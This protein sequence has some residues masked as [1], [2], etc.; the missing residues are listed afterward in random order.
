MKIFEMKTRYQLLAQ[1][2]LVGMFFSQ[3]LF[4][5]ATTFI[6]PTNGVQNYSLQLQATVSDIP[7]TITIE[8]PKET[9]VT[10]Y[11]VYRKLKNDTSWGSV[12]AT[13]PYNA[14]ATTYT[15]V[16]TNV[17]VGVGYEY[18]V[19][20]N[21]P[22]APTVA[23][24]YIY[25][26]INMP[27]VES[28]GK[29]ILVIDNTYEASLITEIAQLKAD[30]AGDGWTVI[31]HSVA[32]NATVPSV[33]AL[34]KA[35]YDADPANVKSVLLLGHVPVPYAGQL[36][37][38][39]HADHLGAWPAD[40]YYAE[41]SNAW[42]D[43]ET[44][45]TSSSARQT[46]IAGDG[47]FD[48]SN[49]PSDVELQIGRIDLANMTVFAPLTE[50]DLLRQYLTKDHQYK[51]KSIAPVTRAMMVDGFGV[52]TGEAF[53]LGGWRN[54]APLVGSANIATTTNYFNTLSTNSYLWTHANGA[55]TTG[56]ISGFATTSNYVT[57]SPRSVFNMMFGSY[58][59]DW[60]ITNDILRAPL[61]S[62]G[63]GLVS[64]WFA[65]PQW[66]FYHMGLGENI[67]YSTRIAQ[68]NTTLYQSLS[69]VHSYDSQIHI[70]LMGDPTLR[71]NVVS[72]V[73]GVNVS[74]PS[75]NTVDISWTASP[76]SG[77]S[78]YHVYRSTS[79]YGGYTRVTTNPVV[80]TSYTDSAPYS[81][82]TYY[83]MV[84]AVKLETTPSGSYYNQS[85][86]V[87][88][89]VTTP[90]INQAP[91][92]TGLST[93]EGVLLPATLTVTAS[94]S[95]DN[96]PTSNPATLLWSTIS[97]PGTVSFSSTTTASTTMTFSDP[98]VYVVQLEAS[99]GALSSQSQITVTASNDAVVPSVPTSLAASN[100]SEHA[101]TLSWTASTDNIAVTGYTI[102]RDA[103]QIGTAATTTYQDSGLLSGTAYTYTIKA[104]DAVHNNSN[105]SDALTVSTTSPITGNSGGGGG[106]S[107]WIIIT[108]VIP[109]DTKNTT[110]TP[111]VTTPV[112]ETS[113]V[114]TQTTPTVTTE[115]K[116]NFVFTQ[117]LKQGSK[118]DEVKELQKY[119]NSKGFV[120]TLTGPGSPGNETNLFSAS[121]KS[122]VTRFQKVLKIKYDK[123]IKADGVVGPQLRKYLNNSKI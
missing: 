74:N 12:L 14:G 101:L 118:G 3:P 84:R 106:G 40:V 32:R 28:R 37:P 94:I 15:Y 13:I 113:T 110:T 115:T 22:S 122:A 80:G 114:I 99:D 52:Y 82:G 61:A 2:V 55:G 102:Y 83:Y 70:A 50:L 58:L 33:K 42:T 41:M 54:F 29:L 17:S 63:W 65:R 1:L 81:G 21:M 49:P 85:Q 27:I 98:G 121:T 72:P 16:D 87:F 51:H 30:L 46:N 60:D 5:L 108:P 109:L 7:P 48:Q 38:D 57:N 47:K 18:Q 123:K 79:Q 92:I 96:L 88:G 20:K 71:N 8:W 91:V 97:G 104:Y 107:S 53:S 6:L 66:H 39:G 116:K 119:L 4:A 11:T 26:G 78:G 93:T 10:N 64:V 67:G 95:D 9:G 120:I 103:T 86:G 73:S 77:L 75:L 59:G 112:V 43:V 117:T 105:A 44:W 100:I 31:S 45:P 34:I 69:T 89:Q 68:Y 56:S 23:F 35:D 24:G 90:A 76:D 19:I 25:S 111:T 62:A 36:N